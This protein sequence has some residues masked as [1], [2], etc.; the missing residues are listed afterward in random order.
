M[1][2]L[3]LQEDANEELLEFARGIL[4]TNLSDV[5]MMRGS[6]ARHRRLLVSGLSP[7]QVYQKLQGA[8]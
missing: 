1:P 3:M 5:T 7:L 4:G 8:L 6:S 2:L